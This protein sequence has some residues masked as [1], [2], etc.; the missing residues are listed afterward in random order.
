MNSHRN[1]LS[2]QHE[3]QHLVCCTDSM[4][5]SVKGLILLV[6]G[7]LGILVFSM[8]ISESFWTMYHGTWNVVYY[9]GNEW[10]AKIAQCMGCWPQYD[11][12]SYLRFLL[13]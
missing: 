6:W 9:L 2:E 10:V 13:W 11:W 3:Y 7:L 8:R 12:M 5:T 4:S 1:M